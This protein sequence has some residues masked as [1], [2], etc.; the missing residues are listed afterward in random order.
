[1]RIGQAAA[2]SGLSVKA[3]RHYDTLGLLGALKRTGAYRD[4]SA[5][6]VQ[7]LKIVARCRNLGFT[8]SEVKRVLD[9]VSTAAPRCPPP[10]AML[11]VVNAKLDSIRSQIR[12]LRETEQ[13]VAKVK[14]HIEA[15]E[16][17]SSP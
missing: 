16:T 8:L 3:I 11:T 17:E 7:N 10:D 4:F 2:T 1:M 12:A 14:R 6:D 5:S 9:L 13:N 15:R